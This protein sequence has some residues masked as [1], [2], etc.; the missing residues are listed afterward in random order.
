MSMLLRRHNR[1]KTTLADV[2]ENV[3][4]SELK[5]KKIDITKLSYKELQALAKE[6][7]I[8]YANVKKADLITALKEVS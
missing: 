3:G 1:V 4:K 5:N 2:T 6:H 8:A 7:K